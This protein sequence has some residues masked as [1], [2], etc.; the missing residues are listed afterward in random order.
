MKA[1]SKDQQ[2]QH[3][4]SLIKDSSLSIFK[5]DNGHNHKNSNNALNRKTSQSNLK[6]HMLNL[7]QSRGNLTS[8]KNHNNGLTS[9]HAA[10]LPPIPNIKH[11]QKA[12]MMH[13]KGVM[14]TIDC[15]SNSTRVGLVNSKS[16]SRF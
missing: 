13:S 1:K 12:L 8:N 10:Q 9:S 2:P 7:Q 16:G 6:N 3:Q 14:S 15:L 4:S 5:V 11:Q